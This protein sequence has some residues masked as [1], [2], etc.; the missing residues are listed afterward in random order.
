MTNHRETFA[1]PS[2]GGG[3]EF[4]SRRVHSEKPLTYAGIDGHIEQ[5]PFSVRSILL[6]P[7]CNWR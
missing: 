5:P 7:Y 2:Q 1:L 6:Q 3:H 4:E